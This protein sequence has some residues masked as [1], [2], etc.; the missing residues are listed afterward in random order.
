MNKCLT[1]GKLF[2][3][4]ENLSVTHAACLTTGFDSEDEASG[5][6]RYIPHIRTFVAE[7]A[8]PM[9]TNHVVNRGAFAALAVSLAWREPWAPKEPI[10][11]D[12]RDLFANEV[13]SEALDAWGAANIKPVEVSSVTTNGVTLI[14]E[15]HSYALRSYIRARSP[16]C[17]P[18][19]DEDLREW[20]KAHGQPFTFYHGPITEYGV[21]W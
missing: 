3:T 21:G 13:F 17:T 12:L 2:E 14:M 15:E 6:E 8:H 10:E 11:D 19:S 9:F 1:C 7:L 4:G 20:S 16:A 5:P 18:F